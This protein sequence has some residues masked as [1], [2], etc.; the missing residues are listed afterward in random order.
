MVTSDNSKE[1]TEVILKSIISDNKSIHIKVKK[2]FPELDTKQVNTILLLKLEFDFNE[3]QIILGVTDAEVAEA[4]ELLV[5]YN[6]K[7]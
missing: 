5:N 6:Q 3:A 2:E 7:Q 1:N 4:Y